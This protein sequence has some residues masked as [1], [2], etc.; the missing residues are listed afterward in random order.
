[1][2]ADQAVRGIALLPHGT[3]KKVRVA[4]FAKG[5]EAEEALKEGV[6]A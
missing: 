5:P 4:M 2:Q 3:G 6:L 1:M